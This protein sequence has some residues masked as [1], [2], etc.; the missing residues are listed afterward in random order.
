MRKLLTILFLSLFLISLVSAWDTCVDDCTGDSPACGAYLDTN[1][2]NLCDHGQ[3]KPVQSGTSQT[4]QLSV[5]VVAAEDSHDILTGQE[6]KELTVTE[7]ATVY[8][9][10]PEDYT[11]ELSK[12]LNI[13]VSNNHPFQLLHDNYG[14]EPSIAKEIALDI[15]NKQTPAPQQAITGTHYNFLPITIFTI[16]L[17]FLTLLLSK[18]KVISLRNHRKIWNIL[19]L[20]TFLI[21]AILGILLV[22]KIEYG[23]AIPLPFN[24]LTWHV[25]AGIPFASISIFHTLWHWPYLKRMFK[26]K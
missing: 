8:N 16:L 12:Y 18:R 14:L 23:W 1:N 22:I 10:N 24:I 20:L 2:D 15:P 11:E 13:K 5:P 21:S 3:P 6:L 25:Y 4:I 19:L 7:V 26:F 17:Y 9:I